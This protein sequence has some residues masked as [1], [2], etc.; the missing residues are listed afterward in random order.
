MGGPNIFIWNEKDD[1]RNWH[2]MDAN[3]NFP[4][5]TLVY[6][7]IVLELRGELKAQR[8]V[9]SVHLIDGLVLNGFDVTNM[10]LVER[11]V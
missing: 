2:R 11:F 1:K 7:E 6:G 5:D 10:H 4:P 3:F 8:R 9:R